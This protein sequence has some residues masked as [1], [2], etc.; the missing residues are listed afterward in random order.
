[1]SSV[2]AFSSGRRRAPKSSSK[3]INSELRITIP[4]RE[5]RPRQRK[6]KPKCKRI[7]AAPSWRKAPPKSSFRQRCHRPDQKVGDP[8]KAARLTREKRDQA[9]PRYASPTNRCAQSPEGDR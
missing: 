9:V 7:R 1:C 3:K 4:S 5:T 8:G 6:G 2:S